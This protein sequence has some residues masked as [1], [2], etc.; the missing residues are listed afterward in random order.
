MAKIMDVLKNCL[1]RALDQAADDRIS[2]DSDKY[3][4]WLSGAQ[5]GVSSAPAEY[6]SGAGTIS[7]PQWRKESLQ[8]PTGGI[9][10]ASNTS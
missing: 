3:L 2:D 4:D 10:R 1:D 9:L 8:R 6:I 7:E 5:L